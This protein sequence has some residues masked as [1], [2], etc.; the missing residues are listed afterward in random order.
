M[1]KW[2]YVTKRFSV[3]L[4][5]PIIKDLNQSSNELANQRPMSISDVFASVLEKLMLTRFESEDKCIPRNQFGFRKNSSCSHATYIIKE[6]MKLTMQRKKYYYIMMFDASKAF[7][8]VKRNKL[9]CISIDEKFTASLIRLFDAYYHEHIVI[10]VNEDMESDEIRVTQGVR[11]GGP[12]SSLLYNKYSTPLLK[13]TDESKLGIKLINQ[14]VSSVGFADDLSALADNS[15]N[16]QQLTDII[17][18]EG[19]KKI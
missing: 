5:K 4:V 9:Q 18:S 16:A 3:T 7:D 11:Q 2:D 13:K 17:S 14:T 12:D 19:K 15:N 1:F 10:I 6:C 8:K